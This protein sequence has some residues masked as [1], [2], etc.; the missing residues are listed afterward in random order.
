M[1]PRTHASMRAAARIVSLA[2]GL[3][4]SC[5][6]AQPNPYRTI[7]H[8]LQ[9]PASARVLGNMSWV[10]VD[11]EG[12]VWAAERCGQNDCTGRD[13]IDPI[14]QFDSSGRPLRGFGAGRFVWPHGLHIDRD[15]NIWVTD[16]RGN[17]E[18]GFQV[19]K[20]SPAGQLL[21]T[22]G[23][24]GVSGSDP[25]LFSGPTDVVVAPDGSIFVTD[26]HEVDSNNR[27]VKYSA[28]GKY[29]LS[30]GGTGS[31][32]GQFL[33]PHAIAMDSTGRVFV[34]DRDN[35][36]IQIFDQDGHFLESWTQ[37]GRPSGLHIAADDTVYVSDNQSNDERNPGVVRGIRIGSAR[38]GVVRAFVPDPDFD[39]R[40]SQETSAHG[41]SADSFG[42]VY[43]AE[44]WSQS[45]KK[46]GGH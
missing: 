38:D 13:G 34:A 35:N 31:G 42:N 11:A 41:L 2:A 22:L 43:G 46:Y 37:F 40:G 28:D 10:D 9:W 6:V 23:K 21:M 36:R 1:K 29:L 25:D 12:N 18:R 17:A 7:D 4:A 27:V 19:L 24:A 5:A 33:V 8:W 15:G 44:V 26:G 45:I 30:W 16:G 3:I 32:Q 39:P 20:F 14:L